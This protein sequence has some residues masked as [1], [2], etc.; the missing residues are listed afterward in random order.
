MCLF[1]YFKSIFKKFNFF[2]FFIYFKLIFLM[3]SDHFNILI[4]KII[5]KKYYFDAFPKKNTLKNKH[6]HNLKHS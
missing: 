2:Y 1:L 5:F 3:F 4:S 6:Y